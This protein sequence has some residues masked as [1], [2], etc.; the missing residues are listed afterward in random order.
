MQEL[1]T[2]LALNGRHHIA[3]RE[4]PCFKLEIAAEDCATVNV[5]VQ[6]HVFSALST[7]ILLSGISQQYVYWVNLA[8]CNDLVP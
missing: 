6:V 4:G 5:A 8:V 1:W 2:L 7:T 3:E